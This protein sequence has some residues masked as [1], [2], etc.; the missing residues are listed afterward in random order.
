MRFNVSKINGFLEKKSAI[1][2]NRC[3]DLKEI[4]EK[5]PTAETQK[6]LEE[7]ALEWFEASAKAGRA[8]MRRR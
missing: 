1:A 6:S 5:N 8:A 4:N 2:W 3:E 7:A